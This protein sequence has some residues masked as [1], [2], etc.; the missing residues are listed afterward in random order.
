MARMLLEAVAVRQMSSLKCWARIALPL[1][2]AK[3]KE[4]GNHA[5][6]GLS[7]P[8]EL[9]GRQQLDVRDPVGG[10]FLRKK[11]EHQDGVGVRILLSAYFRNM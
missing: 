11:G 3:S 6:L 5:P 10:A 9:I 4:R 1:A 2:M 8:V 7:R